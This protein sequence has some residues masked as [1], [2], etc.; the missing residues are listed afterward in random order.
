MPKSPKFRPWQGKL[1]AE[2]YKLYIKNKKIEVILKYQ[3]ST[4]K[5]NI[6]HWDQNSFA[7]VF[8]QFL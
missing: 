7:A 6:K 3:K 8:R 4:K 5:R 1:S 2:A